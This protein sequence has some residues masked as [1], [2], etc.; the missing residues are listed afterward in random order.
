MKGVACNNLKNLSVEFPLGTLITV[1]GVSSSGKSILV[2]RALVE[3]VGEHLGHSRP[4]DEEGADPL[5]GNA[6]AA[7]EG[8]IVSGPGC[9]GTPGS[10][11]PKAH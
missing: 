4:P 1:T 8:R 11:R 5:S 2:S 10:G 7:A 3:L 6:S 9:Y